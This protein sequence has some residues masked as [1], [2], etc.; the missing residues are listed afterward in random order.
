[1]PVHIET[2]LETCVR[3]GASELQL[4]TGAAPVLRMDGALRSLETTTLSAR[5]VIRL[6][7]AVA[8]PAV[9]AD[10]KQSERA[11]FDF[12]FRDR[13]TFRVVLFWADGEP[14]AIFRSNLESK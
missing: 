14:A 9:L 1:M 7:E 11:E 6:A 8:P 2:L 13:G 3:V 4:F 12:R 10:W 5:D